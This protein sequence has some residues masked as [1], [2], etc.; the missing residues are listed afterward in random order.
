MIEKLSKEE[1]L[2]LCKKLP[3]A[4]YEATFSEETGDK[5]EKLCER[6]RINDNL[7]FM[8]NGIGD[9]LLGLLPPDK[10]L[11]SLKSTLKVN[12]DSLRQIIYEINNLIF[13][14]VAQPL[15]EFYAPKNAKPCATQPVAAKP[16]AN[17]TKPAPTAPIQPSIKPVQINTVRPAVARPIAAARPK[18]VTAMPTAPISPLPKKTVPAR[19]APAPTQPRPAT[20]PDQNEPLPQDSPTLSAAP[21]GLRRKVF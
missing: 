10:F 18:P 9:V 17:E 8:V 19:P 1:F 20:L 6:N 15:A 5:I 7:E 12:E 3:D 14:P 16:I 21:S 13:Y 11:D 2:N 4:L